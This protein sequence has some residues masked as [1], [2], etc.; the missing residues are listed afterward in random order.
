M[1]VC[2]MFQNYN[3]NSSPQ[4]IEFVTKETLRHFRRHQSDLRCHPLAANRLI[5]HLLRHLTSF[6][7][8]ANK[9]QLRNN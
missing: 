3:C 7:V 4:A 1:I 9:K 5:Q 6:L 2:N 8:T